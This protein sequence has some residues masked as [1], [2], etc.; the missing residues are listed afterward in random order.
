MNIQMNDRTKSKIIKHN[1]G[2]ISIE[3]NDDEIYRIDDYDKYINMLDMIYGEKKDINTIK[4]N[5]FWCNNCNDDDTLED[6]SQGILVCKKCGYVI[7]NLLDSNTEWF[8][9]G[10]GDR[11][12]NG[13]N[14][15]TVNNLL[16]QSSIST[17]IGGSCASR[18]KIIHNWGTMPYNERS[19][20]TVFKMIHNKC[21]E[22]NIMK[23]I[24]DDAKIL[25]NNI[26]DCKHLVGDNKNKK[27]IFRGVKR[28]AL[29]AACVLYACKKKDKARS[30]KEIAELFGL[31]YCEITK[32]Y[33]KF[34]ELA[35]SRHLEL[36]MNL[37]KPEHFILRLCDKLRIKKEYSEQAIQISN[38]IHKLY[39]ASEHTP[40]SI[41]TCSIYLM[42][43]LNSFNVQ[44]K[45][46]ADTFNVSQVTIGKTFDKLEKIKEVFIHDDLCDKLNGY[47]NDIITNIEITDELKPKF[48][49]FGIYTN[50]QNVKNNPLSIYDVETNT[51]N[52]KLIVEHDI[53]LSNKQCQ[54]DAEYMRTQLNFVNELY[55]ILI[56]NKVV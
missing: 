40:L 20:N 46:I 6:S 39:L 17:S 8:Q 34:M 55:D 2:D 54:I 49:R 56:K 25:F 32:G 29:I 33:K 16:P 28:T 30:P 51:L 37:S 35:K 47:L 36:K 45:T 9:N 15:F 43:Q 13:R 48:I 26:S 24:E 21:V 27:I 12:D 31:K 18:I 22:G 41:A 50:E 38:N 5:K 4:H 14:S 10:D 42:M 23:C 3:A 11:K 53:E 1:I 7:S 52:E 44:K 19:L